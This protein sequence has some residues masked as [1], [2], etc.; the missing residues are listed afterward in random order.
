M[1]Q[2][3]LDLVQ[4]ANHAATSL[5][6]HFVRKPFSDF[7]YI[8]VEPPTW[9]IITTFLVTLL[10]NVGLSYWLIYNQFDDLPQRRRRY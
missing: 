1:S 4:A 5:Q 6:T 3:S 2:G 10:V 9:A 8:K 7:S